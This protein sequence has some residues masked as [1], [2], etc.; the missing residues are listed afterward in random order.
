M[1]LIPDKFSRKIFKKISGYITVFSVI[2][3][4]LIG[5]LF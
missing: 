2:L 4:S 5:I 1:K 3:G